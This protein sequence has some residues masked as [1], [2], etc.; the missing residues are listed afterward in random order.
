MLTTYKIVISLAAFI[1]FAG[2]IQAVTMPASFLEPF[3]VE[4]NDTL[5]RIT[6]HFRFLLLIFSILQALAAVWTF[7]GKIEGIQL[8]FVSGLAMLLVVLLDLIFVKQGVDYP[9]LIFGTLIALTSFLALR[10]CKS[11][12]ISM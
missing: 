3:G 7:L 10:N 11:T 12:A 5:H 6:V 2:F 4:Y 1:H 9:L 8:G